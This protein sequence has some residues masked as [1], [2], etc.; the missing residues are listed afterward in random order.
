MSEVTAARQTD[1]SDRRDFGPLHR[2][3]R[4]RGWSEQKS[5]RNLWH[6]KKHLFLAISSLPGHARSPVWTFSAVHATWLAY[7][8]D[9]NAGATSQIDIKDRRGGKR[10]LL[11]ECEFS[12]HESYLWSSRECS[13]A[14]F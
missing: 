13:R 14:A 8:D 11:C 5:R 9:G 1:G 2:V 3:C 4:I 7:R 12:G 6:R 10:P